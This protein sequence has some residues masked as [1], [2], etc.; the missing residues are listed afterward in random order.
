MPT[1]FHPS[2]IPYP[3]SSSTHPH[4]ARFKC[5]RCERT[6]INGGSRATH[7]T[8]HGKDVQPRGVDKMIVEPP[9]PLPLLKLGML[10][11][12]NDNWSCSLEILI[13][14]ISLSGM[15]QRREAEAA[16]V[17]LDAAACIERQKRKLAESLERQ[18]KRTVDLT[19]EAGKEILGEQRR[20]SA[21]RKQ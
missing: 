5:S 17:A 9:L 21:R 10:F 19:M 6:F 4:P 18:R 1:H 7:E 2:R 15:K 13:D 12:P 16:A 8:F 3:H 20:G 14:G 11:T